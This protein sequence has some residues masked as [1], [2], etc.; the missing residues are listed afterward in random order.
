MKVV[1]NVALL[2]SFIFYAFNFFT[3]CHQYSFAHLVYIYNG[4]AIKLDDLIHYALTPNAF[5]PLTDWNVAQSRL[6]GL[7]VATSQKGFESTQQI[8]EFLYER[9][10]FNENYWSSPFAMNKCKECLHRHWIN[11]SSEL[12]LLNQYGFEEFV[13]GIDQL[14]KYVLANCRFHESIPSNHT[15]SKLKPEFLSKHKRLRESNT[16]S[17]TSETES[18]RILIVGASAAGLVSALSMFK[19][20]LF[21]AASFQLN[22][23]RSFECS[24]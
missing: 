17:I 15:M 7:C 14:S 5:D 4:H 11:S 22:V 21:G 2:S 13:N 10:I 16:N 1:F 12:N 19:S 3:S 18:N 8:K 24:K 9:R 23:R 20:S 6:R